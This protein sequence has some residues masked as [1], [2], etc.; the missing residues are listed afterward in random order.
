MRQRP[1]ADAATLDAAYR[2]YAAALFDYS[3]WASNDVGRAEDAVHAA[4]VAVLG[5]PG[6]LRDGKTLRAWLYAAARKE[7]LKSAEPTAG[8]AVPSPDA[9]EP[10]HESAG[11]EAPAAV[12]PIS[13]PAEIRERLAQVRAITATLTPHEQHVAELAFRHRLVPDEIAV[14]L[15]QPMRAI[16]TT[17]MRVHSA[18]AA[19]YGPEL[20]SAFAGP[21]RAAPD[22]LY[23]RVI[24]SA[25]LPERIA[26]F[27]D[28]LAPYSKAGYPAPP[29]RRESRRPLIAIG[30]VSSIAVVALATVLTQEGP[31]P[32]VDLVVLPKPSISL[33]VAAPLAPPVSAS[34]SASPT[35]TPRPTA[36]R[37]RPSPTP[38]GTTPKP[39]ATSARPAPPA[40]P[41]PTPTVQV[42]ARASFCSR[43]SV[44]VT[45]TVTASGAP[46]KSAQVT[47]RVTNNF[48]QQV[49][50][51]TAQPAGNNSYRA[52]F[53]NVPWNSMVKVE[54][55]AT[56]TAGKTGSGSTSMFTGGCR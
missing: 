48:G 28:R 38:V 22:E 33:S 32:G 1:P 54:G 5:R 34:P 29:D 47:L 45:V 3:L 30:V 44:T 10:G 11:R 7:Q 19:A 15:G 46:T 56:S 4:L 55:T 9:A 16:R 17:I 25:K 12:H 18:L 21:M 2:K 40:P 52:S 37:K 42:N 20:L 43:G 14:V 50:F 49:R 26:Y 51:S 35:P 6:Q 13:T 27:R 53:N 8:A 39:P 41:A 24:G 36:A 23:G 31:R